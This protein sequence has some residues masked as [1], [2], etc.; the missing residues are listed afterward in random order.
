MI[1]FISDKLAKLS[2]YL[3]RFSGF[4]TVRWVANSGFIKTLSSES[5]TVFEKM[6]FSLKNKNFKNENPGPD[7]YVK[8]F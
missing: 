3:E 7:D 5:L 6:P 2:Y 1:F 4:L 8:T